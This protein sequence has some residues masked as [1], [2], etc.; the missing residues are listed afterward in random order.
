M[1]DKAFGISRTP[2]YTA[3]V[4]AGSGDCQGKLMAAALGS[5]SVVLH[6]PAGAAALPAGFASTGVVAGS[7]GAA[8]AATG[9]AAS[10]GGGLSTGA[11]VGIVGG[12]GAAAGAIVVATKSGTMY[13]GPYSGILVFTASG[14]CTFDMQHEGTVSMEIKVSGDTVTGDGEVTGTDMVVAVSPRCGGGGPALNQADSH[15]CCDP[16][17]QVRGTAANL[18][19]SGS[20]PGNLGSVWSYEFAGAL[21][22][23]QI[24]GAF[25][26][27]I[28]DS[29]GSGSRTLPVTLTA[30]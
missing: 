26:L 6:A 10:G 24:T 11:L 5:A 12:V 23:S 19:F 13:S 1:T 20:H 4:A 16:S 22:G 9:A 7:S 25:T 29:G 28:S 8:A 17:P 3:S 27:R 30:R 21:S 14:G 15:G 18:T 2:E